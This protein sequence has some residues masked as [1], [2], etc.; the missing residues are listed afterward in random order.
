[1]P[2]GLF[3]KNNVIQVSNYICS[4]TNKHTIFFDYL[5]LQYL[6]K[7]LADK[8][9]CLPTPAAGS[10]QGNLA[11]QKKNNQHFRYLFSD[12]WFE[13]MSKL[14]A[15]SDDQVRHNVHPISLASCSL[16]CTC[17]CVLFYL[18]ICMSL[19]SQLHRYMRVIL[20]PFEQETIHAYI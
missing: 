17:C 8:N 19:I 4:S 12:S 14:S 16:N 2:L 10:Q 5:T 15:P 6:I 3:P 11:R 7:R 18:Y 1:M 20:I 9:L 13:C